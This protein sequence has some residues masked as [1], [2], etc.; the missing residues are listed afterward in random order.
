MASGVAG[1][2]RIR[3]PAGLALC[4]AGFVLLLVALFLPSLN[5]RAVPYLNDVPGYLALFVGV[6]WYLS[7]I[8]LVLAPLITVTRSPRLKAAWA[9]V[10]AGTFLMNM[11][12][13]PSVISV[14]RNDVGVGYWVWTAAFAISGLGTS[15]AALGK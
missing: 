4:L 13:G 5:A 3:S 10:L 6:P 15:L 1:A 9:V 11:T 7:N 14:S 12:V 2:S 8:A